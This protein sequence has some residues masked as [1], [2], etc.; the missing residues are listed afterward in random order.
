MINLIYFPKFRLWIL[1]CSKWHWGCLKPIFLQQLLL[2]PQSK[3]LMC[4]PVWIHKTSDIPH[5]LGGCPGN[6]SWTGFNQ[7][8][9]EPEKKQVCNLFSVLTN[10]NFHQIEYFYLAFLRMSRH[11]L[12]LLRTGV[13]SCIFSISLS[14]LFCCCC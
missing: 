2:S 10:M 6:T 5:S 8:G 14:Y 7:E 9:M 13:P 12:C 4:Y 11:Q 1:S 3:D